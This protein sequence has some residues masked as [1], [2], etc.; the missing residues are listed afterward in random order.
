MNEQHD[1]TK[2]MLL[3]EFRIYAFD[4]LLVTLVTNREVLQFSV[5]QHTVGFFSC[6]HAI[7]KEAISVSRFV[8]PSI[9]PSVRPWTRVEKCENERFR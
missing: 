8:G 7:L 2:V 6:G 3:G 9:G 5:S 4:S 1:Y